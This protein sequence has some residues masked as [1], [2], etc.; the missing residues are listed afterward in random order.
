MMCK[1]QCN[2]CE[3]KANKYQ[4]H[5]TL[6]REYPAFWAAVEGAFALISFIAPC[7]GSR[8]RNENKGMSQKG[9][10]KSHV[11]LKIM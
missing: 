10:G 7:T 6:L 5:C 4:A 11:A 2:K 8:G 3:E 9:S 1:A